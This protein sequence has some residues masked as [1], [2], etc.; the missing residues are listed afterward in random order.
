[1][2]ENLLHIPDFLKRETVGTPTRRTARKKQ[3]WLTGAPSKRPTK[4]QVK[5]LV[6]REWTA[7]QVMRLSR[8][9]AA[10]IVKLGVGPEARF[11]KDKKLQFPTPKDD[12]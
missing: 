5:V 1:M 9:E 7:Q 3:K 2:N 10:T 6:K 8:D 4:A 12:E 11:T